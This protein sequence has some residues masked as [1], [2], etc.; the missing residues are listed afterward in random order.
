M[1]AAAGFVS[2]ITAIVG[3]IT[4]LIQSHNTATAE[5]APQKKAE[6]IDHAFESHDAMAEASVLQSTADRLDRLQVDE[7]ARSGDPARQ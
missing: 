5:Q 3:L 6:E 2:L 7:A 4:Y 1:D